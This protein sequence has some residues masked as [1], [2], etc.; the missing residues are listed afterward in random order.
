M[1]KALIA[2]ALILVAAV[3]A[4]AQQVGPGVGG[5]YEAYVCTNDAGGRLSLRRAP[6]QGNR[7]LTQIPAGNGIRVLEST[8]GRDG[9]TWMK[10]S[11]RGQVGWVRAD[12]VCVN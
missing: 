1:F 3:P 2:S 8:R 11:Y 9:F 10:V 6:G 7:V 5:G 12:Y 4:N